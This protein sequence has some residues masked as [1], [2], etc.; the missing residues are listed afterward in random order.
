MTAGATGATAATAGSPRGATRTTGSTTAKKR[1]EGPTS[2]SGGAGAAPAPA[3]PAGH[4]GH[5][6]HL[7]ARARRG[8]MARPHGYTRPP[9]AR[10]RDGDASARRDEWE[11]TPGGG[12]QTRSVD[13]RTE[14]VGVGGDG[15]GDG[16]FRGSRPG[17]AR[18]QPRFELERYVA[19]PRAR[20]PG[21]RTRG[22]V[23]LPRGNRKSRRP[24]N[25]APSAVF[26]LRGRRVQSRCVERPKR[27]G[28]GSRGTTMTKAGGHGDAYV[29][30]FAEYD[31]ARRGVKKRVPKRLRDATADR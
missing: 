22:C 21:A 30:A 11:E 9:S 10:A 25:D 14:P 15:D 17:S 20:L 26:P 16:S 8:P 1:V 4:R 23:G 28:F 19:T 29:T 6:G 5:G 7:G 3:P 31:G 13:G 12:G 24:A 2:R 27:E 18:G